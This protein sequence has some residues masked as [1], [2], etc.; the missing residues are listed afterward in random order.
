MFCHHEKM[1]TT[2]T[3]KKESK[4]LIGKLGIRYSRGIDRDNSGAKKRLIVNSLDEWK[5]RKWK[6]ININTINESLSR[7]CAPHHVCRGRVGGPM[8]YKRINVECV[9]LY[10]YQY[11]VYDAVWCERTHVD[12]VWS[13]QYD[14]MRHSESCVPKIYI[15][16]LK[17]VGDTYRRA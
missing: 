14:K 15:L 5:M 2:T 4:P 1:K 16:H 7:Y 17:K 11:N 3:T 13:Y 9:C 8:F 10:R 6:K 12:C